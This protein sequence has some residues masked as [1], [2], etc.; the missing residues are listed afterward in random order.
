MKPVRDLLI[1]FVTGLVFSLGLL[2][3]GMA[4]PVKVK[5]FLDVFGNWDPS[6]AFVMGGAIL[7]AFPFFRWR[8]RMPSP[9][10]AT[11]ATAVDRSLIIG[12]LL[13]GIGWGVSGYCPGPALVASSAGNGRALWY[14]FAMVLGIYAGSRWPIKARGTPPE[15]EADGANPTSD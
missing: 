4:S 3:S 1:A 13:F 5:A 11:T 7:L 6:L 12:S 14:V 2:I 8:D 9:K 15:G 10:G